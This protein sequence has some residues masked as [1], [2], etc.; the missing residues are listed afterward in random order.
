MLKHIDNKEQYIDTKESNDNEIDITYFKI[1]NN[2]NTYILGLIYEN[3][4]NKTTKNID[5]LDIKINNLEKRNFKIIED[6]KKITTYLEIN[7]DYCRIIIKNKIILDEIKN[8]FKIYHLN[9]KIDLYE[10]IKTYN[11]EYILGFILVFFEERGNIVLDN[12]YCNLYIEG[13]DDSNLE[14]INLIRHKINIPSLRHKEKLVY[15]NV[16][17]IDILG[18]FYNNCTFYNK[19]LYD[20]YIEI[21]NYNNKI[22]KIKVYK[23]VN[24]A[25]IPSK[26]RNSDAGFDLTIIKKVKDLT[27]VTSLYDT[28]IKL[29]IPNGYYVEVFPRSSLSKSGYMLANSV[30]IIDQGYTGNILIALTRTNGISED[31]KLPFKCCQMI[32]KKQEYVILEEIKEELLETDR[33]NGGFGSTS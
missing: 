29:E 4:E 21:I 17:C 23:E 24:N 31:I 2:K 26:S 18:K 28:G 11:I 5:Y 19:E 20:K 1:L 15:S 27:N 14:L 30:G 3:I 33:A 7:N 13:I 16:N 12:D 25:V 6:L 8:I 22:P 9:D 32:L 10:F